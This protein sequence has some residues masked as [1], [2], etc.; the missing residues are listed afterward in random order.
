MSAA[1]KLGCDYTGHEF[2]GGFPHSVC[3]DGFLVCRDRPE[4]A[5]N[6]IDPR[7]RQ[8]CPRCN[9]ERML[10]RALDTAKD[11]GAGES[12]AT[13]DRPASPWCAA[14]EWEAA[15]T[16][17]CIENGSVALSF[18]YSLPPFETDDWP[19]RQAVLDGRG[20]WDD[21]V[22]VTYYG[23]SQ[24]KEDRLAGAAGTV[25]VTTPTPPVAA[26][27]RDISELAYLPTVVAAKFRAEIAEAFPALTPADLLR[28][29]SA[30]GMAIHDAL[31][32]AIDVAEFRSE[33]TP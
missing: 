10:R 15:C 19:D 18:L 13:L 5:I 25:L 9:T 17:A 26:A 23:M 22:R 30:V 33:P 2:R 32:R 31:M 6:P 1:A 12:L 20:R 4:T 29:S 24:T 27:A 11:G 21:T 8:A 28:A 14:T 7:I 3:A 16:R